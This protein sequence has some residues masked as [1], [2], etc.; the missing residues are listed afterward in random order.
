MRLMVISEP[1]YVF[2]SRVKQIS[3]KQAQ[4]DLSQHL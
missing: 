4:G 2:F 1:K 3:R